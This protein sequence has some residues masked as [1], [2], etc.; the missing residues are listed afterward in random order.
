MKS[1]IKVVAALCFAAICAGCAYMHYNSYTIETKTFTE[2]VHRGD[3]VDEILL[4]HFN[5]ENEGVIFEEFKYNILHLEKNKHLL[6][7][8]GY[9]KSLE[10]GTSIHIVCKVKVAK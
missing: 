9:L 5:A 3:T 2:V 1:F 7:K 8:N 6:N 4:E 10:P